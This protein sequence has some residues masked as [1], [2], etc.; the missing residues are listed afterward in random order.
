[1]KYLQYYP[2]DIV[3]GEG[4]RCTLFVSGCTHGCRGCYNQ[5]SW[6]FD[7]GVL[8]DEA[9]EQQIINDLKDT[10]IKRQGLTLSGGDQCILVMLKPYFLLYSV[11]KRMS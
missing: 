11:S 8:F 10:R 2:T 7:N 3:N 4:T 1:M 9:M 6:S 5:K